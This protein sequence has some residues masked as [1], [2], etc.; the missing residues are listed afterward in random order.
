MAGSITIE[1]AVR[2]SGPLAD[3]TASRELTDAAQAAAKELAETGRDWVRL[4]AEDMDRSGRGGTGGASGGVRL[5]G[6]GGSYRVYGGIHQGEFSWPW[7]EGTS[8]R[9]KTTPFHGYH[10]FRK[11]G[12]QLDEI[13]GDV[14][15]KHVAEIMPRIGGG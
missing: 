5:S 13:A 3:G 11:T 14:L 6:S 12:R 4:A 10:T 15:Q 9:N 8:K 1:L 7:L 2:V